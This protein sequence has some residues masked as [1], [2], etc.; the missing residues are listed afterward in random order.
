M[1][2]SMVMLVSASSVATRCATQLQAEL[3][4]RLQAAPSAR[5]ALALLHA[6]PY[7]AV[8]IDESVADTDPEYVDLLVRSLNGAV[9]VFVNLA[10]NS[11]DRVARELRAAM[12]RRQREQVEAFE[13]ARL[14]LRNE[15]KA[16]L[17]GLLLSSQM[18]LAVP[19]MPP[20]AQ[21]KLKSVYQL[22][23]KIRARLEN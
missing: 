5:R 23:E 14:A 12:A 13:M 18:A 11:F 16:D 4:V 8:A 10:I 6:A 15:L 7:E 20:A 22:A 3:G 1:K 21:N 19:A 2:K 17:T 9:P